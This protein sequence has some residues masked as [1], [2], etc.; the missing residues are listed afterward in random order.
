MTKNS[1]APSKAD[2][3]RAD[4][5]RLLSELA[6]EPVCIPIPERLPVSVMDVC[7][8]KTIL[9]RQ[10]DEIVGELD[11]TSS[12]W[13]SGLQYQTQDDIRFILVPT[14]LKALRELAADNKTKS[15]LDLQIGVLLFTV[16]EM[17]RLGHLPVLV[18]MGRVIPENN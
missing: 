15:L 11:Q 8:Y 6:N 13:K 5:W 3:A 17:I 16:R 9:D 2:T 14:M 12:D 7:D 1:N 18:P 4:F 10:L